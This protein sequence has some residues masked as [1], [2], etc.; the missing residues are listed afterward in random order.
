MPFDPSY[1]YYVALTQA[2]ASSVTVAG[3][4]VLP[5]V[6][7]GPPNFCGTDTFYDGTV[8]ATTITALP[9]NAGIFAV[10]LVVSPYS[11]TT[12]SGAAINGTAYMHINSVPTAHFGYIEGGVAGIRATQRPYNTNVVL[13]CAIPSDTVGVETHAYVPWARTDLGS[14][15]IGV[16]ARYDRPSF[17]GTYTAVAF[18]PIVSALNVFYM[19]LQS[20]SP[21][22]GGAGDSVSVLGVGFSSTSTG[23]H[24]PRV[25]F[26]GVLATNIVVVSDTQ[27]TCTVPGI[28]GTV[29][30]QVDVDQDAYSEF[31]SFTA[32]TLLVGGFTGRSPMT[33]SD[34]ATFAI[35]PVL[36]LTGDM[37]TL[38]AE[39]TFAAAA[40]FA[41][42]EG[43]G[44]PINVPSPA[45]TTPSAD[46]GQWG[47]H[48]LDVKIRREEST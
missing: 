16:S 41:A 45:T 9:A 4:T 20:V 23:G 2:G 40:T 33:I 3:G 34:E 43:T 24:T 36:D 22:S 31:P 13:V 30:V 17:A 25:Y 14:F 12:G 6:G 47:L 38:N 37:A 48:R 1:G 11:T 8:Y 35:T 32:S 46:T 5:D 27:I 39:A 29:D 28:G 15:G 21:S 18:H 19:S 10:G 44:L 42:V 26:G 7:G